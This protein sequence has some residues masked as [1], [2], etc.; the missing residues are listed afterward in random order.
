[1][2][3]THVSTYGLKGAIVKTSFAQLYNTIKQTNADGQCA[4]QL[5]GVE[6]PQQQPQEQATIQVLPKQE[7]RRGQRGQPAVPKQQVLEQEEG[8]RGWANPLQLREPR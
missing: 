3:V 6:A 4:A 5:R 1:M 7:P 8:R 2:I